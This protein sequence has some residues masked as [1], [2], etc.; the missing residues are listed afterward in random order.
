M[1][2]CDAY[3]SLAV[4][5]PNEAFSRISITG[6]ELIIE[7]PNFKHTKG[8]SDQWLIELGQQSIFRAADYLGIEK[9]FIRDVVVKHQPYA[10]ILPINDRDRKAFMHWA[11][12]KHNIFSLGR[13]ATWRPG[14]LLD[15]LVNDVRLIDRWIG[16]SYSVARHR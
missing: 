12:D 1:D 5:D 4:P 14:L 7:V 10:K 13:Y 2:R 16:D 8:H 3:I 11:T 6:D 15:D 9:D